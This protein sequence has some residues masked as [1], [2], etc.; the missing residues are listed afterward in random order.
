MGPGDLAARMT[1]SIAQTCP[2]GAIIFVSS[3]ASVTD[4]FNPSTYKHAAIYVGA[5]D[6]PRLLLRATGGATYTDA[7][8][9]YAA[10]VPCVI[11]ASAPHG[12]RVTPLPDLLR[13]CAVVKAYRLAVPGA[14]AL[15]NLAAD[16]AF[17][18]VGTPYGF[19]R[20][21]TYCFKLVADCFASV[22]IPTR[23]RRIMGREVVLSQDFLDNGLW[24][25]ILDSEECGGDGT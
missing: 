20:G 5:I 23:T 6:A 8:E 21:R 10:G 2:R 19:N 17:E 1:S 4:C 3:C 13:N 14:G 18:L 22:G 11:D 16:A 7:A 12:A 9:S 24:T 15:M 25:K